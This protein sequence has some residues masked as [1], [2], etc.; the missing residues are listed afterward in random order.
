MLERKKRSKV[1]KVKRNNKKQHHHILEL[2]KL[3]G[4]SRPKRNS[5]SSR[6][7]YLAHPAS[8]SN[9]S[10]IS[11]TDKGDATT[12]STTTAESITNDRNS[13][14]QSTRESA[15]CKSIGNSHATEKNPNKKKMT[16]AIRELRDFNGLGCKSSQPGSRKRRSKLTDFWGHSDGRRPNP[17]NYSYLFLEANSSVQELHRR[18]RVNA[19]NNSG[20]NLR[21]TRRKLWNWEPPET[22]STTSTT[23]R[24]TIIANDS[25]FDI[26]QQH[27]DPVKSKNYTSACQENKGL[28]IPPA[29]RTLPCEEDAKKDNSSPENTRGSK[30]MGINLRR[31]SRHIWNW[32]PPETVAT[33][34]P[35]TRGT[36]MANDSI[37]DIQQQ[38]KGSVKPKNT[39]SACP[40]K[41]GFVISTASRT[42][43]SEEGTVDEP[44]PENASGSKQIGSSNPSNDSRPVLPLILEPAATLPSEEEG[45][46]EE[47]AL[48]KATT[49]VKVSDPLSESIFET[50]ELENTTNPCIDRNTTDTLLLT[51]RAPVGATFCVTPDPSPTDIEKQ[52]IDVG[53]LYSNELKQGAEENESTDFS[54]LETP[55]LQEQK[56]D[57]QS[58]DI[59]ND[60]DIVYSNEV[61]QDAEKNE[62]FD[63]SFVAAPSLQEQK[64]DIEW[65]NDYGEQFYFCK[66][67]ETLAALKSTKLEPSQDGYP[68][69]CSNYCHHSQQQQHHY[70]ISSENKTAIEGLLLLPIDPCLD[71]NTVFPC[72]NIANSLD[73]RPSSNTDSDL[74]VCDTIEIKRDKKSRTATKFTRKRDESR[75]ARLC[76][77][78]LPK[79]LT[80]LGVPRNFDPPNSAYQMMYRFSGSYTSST[81]CS[82]P[83]TPRKCGDTNGF[84]SFSSKSESKLGTLSESIMGAIPNCGAL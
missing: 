46:G 1:A 60:I 3:Y 52:C 28:I 22:I 72:A 51:Q 77:P 49:G 56:F 38:P 73:W 9:N 39:S 42:S 48:K 66:G 26:Q 17:C 82:H 4:V 78:D 63:F 47:L 30:Q 62:S 10:E 70:G 45:E 65:E 33:M 20:K 14:I 41:K 80:I 69:T 54:C 67:I 6:Q 24:A 64:F 11:H 21:R 57:K 27:K 8:N 44:S 16:R 53:V 31:R 19:D 61:K 71:K 83:R 55:S 79:P 34:A 76:P 74:H 18:A 7:V 35:K 23:T 43:P 36:A 5:S 75:Q 37:L 81:G 32:E 40:N 29:S 13:E 15:S 2:K 58:I 84:L 25:M 68:F 59:D 12:I 50:K